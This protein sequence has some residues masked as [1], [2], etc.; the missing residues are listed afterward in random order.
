MNDTDFVNLYLERLMNEVMELTKIKIIS[1]TK[2]IFLEK[3]NQALLEQNQN[4]I[5]KLEKTQKKNLNKKE[6]NVSVDTF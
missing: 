2:I 4:L 5:D 6:T 3:S 1:E